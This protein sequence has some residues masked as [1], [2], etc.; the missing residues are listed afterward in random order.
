MFIATVDSCDALPPVVHAR[1]SAAL[2]V[3]SLA[4]APACDR[5]ADNHRTS[6]SWRERRRPRE[7][8]SDCEGSLLKLDA[9][10]LTHGW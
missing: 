1:K 4:G 6:P 7:V 3:A 10:S 5:P 2:F 8:G 9:Q